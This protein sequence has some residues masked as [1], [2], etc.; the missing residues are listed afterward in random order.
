MN[1]LVLGGSGFLGGHLIDELISEGHSVTSIDVAKERYRNTP[2]A[3]HFIEADFG[4]R[5]ELTSIFEE[6]EID[7]V[8]H[9]VSTTLPGT[10]NIDPLFDIT[11]NL[12]ES[13]ALLDLCVRFNV[14]KFIYFS[15]GG[16]VYGESN[17]PLISEEHPTFPICS[18]GIVK[19]AFEKY[20]Q[21]YWRL[22]G[23]NYSILRISNPYGPRQDP[24]KMQG[25]IGV[26][27]HKM[28]TNDKIVIWGDG[29]VIRDYV[30]VGDVVK[31]ALL[32]IKSEQSSLVNIGS[33]VGISL[34]ELLKKLESLLGVSANIE[35][36]P[37]RKF[38]IDRMVLDCSRAQ[39]LLGWTATTKL[40]HGLESMR[41]WLAEFSKIKFENKEN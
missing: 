20:I 1:I 12:I 33:G 11:T 6:K 14:K 17:E 37:G 2:S 27:M 18:Y 38:D 24:R 25:A 9:L 7:V 32:A 29:S 3:I 41:L 30:Y 40:E 23:L 35:Y 36:R 28:L 16:T 13:V 26:F 4:N 31:A 5:G 21:M 10:S 39:S 19:L 8:I 15:S 34:R 22:H